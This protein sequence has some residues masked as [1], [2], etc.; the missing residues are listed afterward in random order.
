MQKHKPLLPRK[1]TLL[2]AGLLFF[3]GV[4]KAQSVYLPQ[5]YQFYQ[6]FNAEVYSTTNG[7]HTSLRPFLVDSSLTNR[8]TE[9]MNL[10][11]KKD[12]NWVERKLFNEHLLQVDDKEYT[13]YADILI[14][15]TF[16]KDFKDG[17][18]MPSNFKPFGYILK[19]PLGI[20]TRGFQVGGTIGSKF[21]FYT[22]AF[23]N[24]AI[25]P[26]YYN[27]YV[28][29]TEFVPGLAYDRSFGKPQKDWS[30]VT[31]LLSYT[32]NKYLNVTLGQD[33]TFIGDGY[34]S[35]LLSDFAANYPFLRATA[36]IGPVQYM[37]M[38]T[39]LQ[40]IKA[41]KFDDFGSN[42]RKYA[43]YHYFDWNATK[44]LSLGFFN[45]VVTP[46]ADDV[47][48]R[49]GF[50][51]N[52]INPL[53]F[54]SGNN[55]VTPNNVLFG[56]TGKYKIFNKNALYAQVILD[57]Q[58][59]AG[60]PSKSSNG[61]QVGVRGGDL[62]GAKN[63]SYLFEFNTVKP[64]T[65]SDANMLASYTFYGDPLAHPL[66]AN[67]KEFVGLLNYSIG[68]F[69][70]QGQL[71]YA[72][73]GLDA[74]GE[75]NGKNINAPYEVTTPTSKIAQGIKTDLYYAEGTVSFLMNPK[76]NLRFELGGL[77]RVEKNTIADKRNMVLTFGV[78]TSFRNL[79]HDF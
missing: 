30:Y 42:R 18:D 53:F 65:Y 35:L 52:Y 61:Y 31:A 54:T 17:K 36:N 57:N 4:T 19:T 39:Y 68:R 76:Y 46:E 24:Q 59:A 60:G 78:R 70:L 45:A 25:F 14:D 62:A 56:F 75:N 63:L 77:Y 71:N 6:K 33:K 26:S 79:Y 16:G 15:N 1:F 67:F 58:K 64:Y 43:I 5:S 2:I 23:E 51:I 49:H 28:N 73:Y 12:R 22:S 7:M 41:P 11:V 38:W 69:D 48:N 74:T 37:M 72:K 3:T 47:D 20:N 40:D 29:T 44:S 10:G 27:D 66:G 55:K 32:P 21:S 13:F 50:D 34:R 8:Y 9:L